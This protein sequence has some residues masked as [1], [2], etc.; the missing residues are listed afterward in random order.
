MMSQ[1]IKSQNMLQNIIR[2]DIMGYYTRGE[3]ITRH[4]ITIHITLLK[5]YD[6]TMTV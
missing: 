5:S 6:I 3:D 1:D 2:E 4:E